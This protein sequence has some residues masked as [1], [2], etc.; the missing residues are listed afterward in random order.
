MNI[1]LEQWIGSDKYTEVSA[2]G[3]YCRG[4]VRGCGYGYG[5]G[6]DGS[7]GYSGGYGWGCGLDCRVGSH[8]DGDEYGYG[9]GL[10]EDL[11]GKGR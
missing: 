9:R 5:R 8:H 1:E 7:T 11:T 3:D 4:S 10:A 6:Y 2:D